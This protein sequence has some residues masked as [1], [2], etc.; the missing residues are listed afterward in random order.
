MPVQHWAGGLLDR[1]EN[2]RKIA[3]EHLS[4]RPMVAKRSSSNIVAAFGLALGAVCGMAGSLVAQPNLQAVLW[5]IDAAGLVM[6]AA[7]LS[8]KYF[9]MERDIV[10]AGFMVF[11]IAEA[12]ILS[13]TAAGLVASVPSFAAG[14]ALWATAL[15]LISI[16]NQFAMPVRLLGLVSAILL[17]IVATRIFWGEQILPT[18]TPLPFYAYPFLV[19]TFIGWIWT[20][21]REVK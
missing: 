13:G 16:P 19:M 11:A 2:Q 10:A 3:A 4:R 6:A 9:R 14:T 12:V 15:L 17:F 1:V 7:I 20:L 5:G 21:L 8:L 18:S